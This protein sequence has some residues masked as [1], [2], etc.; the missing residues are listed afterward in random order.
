M[1]PLLQCKDS[2]AASLDRQDKHVWWSLSLARKFL[3]FSFLPHHTR[4]KDSAM[5]HYSWD[6]WHSALIP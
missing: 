4:P 1:A 5:R 2:K 6:Q 3:E